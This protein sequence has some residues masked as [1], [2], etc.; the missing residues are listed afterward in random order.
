MACPPGSVLNP[1]SYKCVQASGRV[2]RGLLQEGVIADANIGYAGFAPYYQRVKQTRKAQKQKQPVGFPAAFAPYYGAEKAAKP[3]AQP[4][5]QCAPGMTR[6]PRSGRCIAVGGKT[7]KRLYVPAPAPGPVYAPVY[8]PAYVPAYAPPAYAPP[9]APAIKQPPRRTTSDE[10]ARLPVGTA[11]VIP[12]ADRQT[13]LD[14]TNAN[15]IN[16]RDAVTGRDFKAQDAST[17]QEVIRLHN[18]TCVLATGMNDR[19]YAQHTAGQVATLPDGSAHMTL[20]DFTALRAAMRRR[21]PAY[22]IPGRKHQPPPANWQLYISSD[23]R[24]GP[25]FASVFYVDV[26][27]GRRTMSGVEFPVDA[28]ML[29]MGFIPVSTAVPGGLC[30]P[31]TLV[32]I[33]KKVSEDNK[34][35][36]P[37]AGGWKPVAGFPFSKK[38]WGADDKERRDRLSRLCRELANIQ[39]RPF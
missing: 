30:S 7:Y 21:N 5:T 25:D 8:A 24:S 16:T 4:A 37:V 19:I 11:T 9:P 29:D 39:V 17:L 31:T 10:P 36:T 38:Y 34:L 18:R 1:R 23:N 6:N 3:I 14:W 13:M 27:R 28:I 32:G 35:L 12:L 26:T 22:K 15:C 20:D 33:M 2:A